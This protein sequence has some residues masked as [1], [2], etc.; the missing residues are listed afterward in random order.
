MDS[1]KEVTVGIQ[2]GLINKHAS[3]EIE[4]RLGP[5]VSGPLNLMR[6]LLAVPDLILQSVAPSGLTKTVHHRIK[7]ALCINHDI[8]TRT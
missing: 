2:I 3:I 6:A 7:V 1:L 8:K 4:R 5:I